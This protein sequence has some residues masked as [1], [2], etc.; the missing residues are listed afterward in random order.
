M[1]EGR[2]S[3]VFLGSI[4][5]TPKTLKYLAS[6]KPNFCLFIYW[7]SFRTYMTEVSEIFS[8]EGSVQIMAT[9]L[10]T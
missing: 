9:P 7:G 3:T 5:P 10:L 1:L 2:L 4:E 8:I 6:F